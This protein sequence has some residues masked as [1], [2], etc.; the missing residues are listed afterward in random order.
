MLEVGFER[1]ITVDFNP[2]RM[3]K[4]CFGK[5]YWIL[6]DMKLLLSG[7]NLC[8]ENIVLSVS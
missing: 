7:L 3:P 4:E 2:G 6:T 8:R 5:T 1:C